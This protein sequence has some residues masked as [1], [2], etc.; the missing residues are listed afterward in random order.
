MTDTTVPAPAPAPSSRG[1]N[2][3]LWVGLFVIL[4]VGLT[5]TLLFTMTDAAMFRGRYIV[6]TH[7]PNAGGIRKGDP[8][9]M[10]GVNIGRIQRFMISNDGV[11]LRLEIEGE[12]MVPSDSKVELVSAGLL[13]GMVA[14]VIPGTAATGA[15]NGAI[16]QGTMPPQIMDEANNIADQTQKVL[17]RAQALLSDKT[18]DGVEASAQEL[19]GLLKELSATTTEQRKELKVLTAS[20]RVTSANIEK[21]TSG[22]ELE[23][24]IKRLDGISQKTEVSV[25]SL[26]HGTHSL[27]EVLGRIE[28]G[29]GTFGKLSKDEALYTSI[30]KTV[31]NL[32][33]A[34]TDLRELLQDLKKNP[35]RYVKLSLF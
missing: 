28:R 6:T 29:E 18:V 10:R 19:Q 31:E 9:Q 8:V 16:L 33:G 17:A 30:N 11:D 7:L 4:G 14:R 34:S 1:K 26:E 24:A 2:R 23:R 21:A 27:E 22:P 35:K 25:Q 32:N 5:M 3:E 12:Y 15:R 20:L 13:G